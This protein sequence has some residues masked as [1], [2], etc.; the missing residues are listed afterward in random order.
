MSPPSDASNLN[1]DRPVHLDLKKDQGLTVKWGDGAVS[2]F[3]IRYLRAMSPSADARELRDQ[4]ASNPLAVIPPD[5]AQALDK[6]VTA[7]DAQMVG[8]YALRIRFSD[9]HDTG[10]Y[11]WTYLREIDR[12]DPPPDDADKRGPR[13]E[14]SA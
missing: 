9:G 2:F 14:G 5:V 12:G 10:L 6:P 3:P 13:T 1:R 4:M 8:N 7:T 11:S